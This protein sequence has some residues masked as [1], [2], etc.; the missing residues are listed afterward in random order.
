MAEAVDSEKTLGIR[1]EPRLP[2]HTFPPPMVIPPLKQPHQQTII[3]LHGRGSSAKLF[4]PELL[5][6]PLDNSTTSPGLNA[7]TFRDL[8]PH[9][10]F[11]FPTAPR[12]RATIY[13][14]AI[15]NQWYDGSGDWEDTLL[16]HAKET[17]L[18][19]HSLLEDEAIRLGGTDKVVLGGFSQ[20]CAA[21]LVCLLLWRGTPLG[22]ILGSDDGLFEHSDGDSTTSWEGNRSEHDPV[23]RALRILGDEIGITVAELATRPSFLGTPVFLGH[24]TVDDN[25]PV[26]YGQ[27]AARVLRAMGCE[28]DFKAYDGLDH[29]YSKDMLKDMIGFLGDIAP[30]SQW[31]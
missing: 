9:T 12:S 4:A 14:R 24:G 5:S 22:G 23:E 16:G 8:L 13:R 3:L 26:R 25:V 29:C 11:V 21:A 28:V 30:G 2:L 27:E 17:V 6:V 19:I 18:F 10:R 20:G 31:S 7:C 15:I 1:S